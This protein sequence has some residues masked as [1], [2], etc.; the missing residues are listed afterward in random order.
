M[1]NIVLYA[2]ESLQQA[3]AEDSTMDEVVWMMLGKNYYNGVL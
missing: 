3:W 1:I 2:I